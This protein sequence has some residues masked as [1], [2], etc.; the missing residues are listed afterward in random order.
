MKS[1]KRLTHYISALKAN[2]LSL[3]Q[4][5]KQL[6][7]SASSIYREIKRNSVGGRYI[8]ERAQ[9]KAFKRR[10]AVGPRIKIEGELTKKVKEGQKY[11]FS[12]RISIE[13][14]KAHKKHFGSLY[15]YLGRNR[16]CCKC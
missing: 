15:F 7:R 4:I 8:P 14:F 16:I 9:K 10:R 12:N 6:N 13:A 5:G 3:R 11:E 2:K 1:Y